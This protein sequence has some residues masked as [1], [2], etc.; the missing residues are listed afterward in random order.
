MSGVSNLQLAIYFA[1]A[2]VCNGCF[3][4]TQALSDAALLSYASSEYDKRLAIESRAL[5][6]LNG[7]DVL[8][9]Y[10]CGDVCPNYTVRVIHFAVE[11]GPRCIE[12]GGVERSVV[13]PV[14]IAAMERTFCFPRILADNWESY[15]R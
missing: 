12:A 9:D 2:C 14:A 13:I 8:V 4:N 7:T 3:R 10:F 15:V 11:P 6:S 1:F 5:G